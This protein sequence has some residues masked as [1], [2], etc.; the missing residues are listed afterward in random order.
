LKVVIDTNCFISCI[1][2]K[3]PYRNG[4]DA[5]IDGKYSLFLSTEI[6]LEYEEKFSLFWG[7]EVSH[8]LLGVLL[9]SENISLHVVYFNFHLVQ[10]DADDNKF[11]DVYL[12][13]AADILVSNDSNVLKISENDFPPVRVMRLE[14]F[15]DFI[16]TNV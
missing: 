3:S 2:K 11:A 14:T 4:F 7:N 5:F 1:G 16:K 12:S 15:A 13:S 6:L 10:G 9:T 8:N